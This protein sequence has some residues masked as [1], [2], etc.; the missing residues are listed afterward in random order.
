MC[1]HIET[2]VEDQTFYLTQSQYTGLTSSSTDPLS[3]G[4]VGTGAP[5]FKSLVRLYLEKSRRK[6]D[7]NRRSS[8]LE[9]EALTTR[10]TRW[11][12]PRWTA[13]TLSS[14][15]WNCRKSNFTK[16]A[17]VRLKK[18]NQNQNKKQNNTHTCM[19]AH[20]HT[21]TK[22]KNKTK[23]HIHKHA[24][25]CA[26]MHIHTHTHTHKKTNS[27]THTYNRSSSNPQG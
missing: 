17:M 18:T 12:S 2:E 10:L 6:R 15:I 16:P 8:A 24:R 14:G 1:S 5:I 26:H 27:C 19:H 21:H 11:C 23:Q 7:S 13:S 20:T 4:R 22:N 9:A 3:P 25:T